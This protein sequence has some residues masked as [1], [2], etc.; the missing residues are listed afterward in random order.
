MTTTRNRLRVHV[1]ADSQVA[2]RHVDG[3]P[4]VLLIRSAGLDIEL[5]LPPD[6]RFGAVGPAVRLADRTAALLEYARA[7]GEQAVQ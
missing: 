4:L 1:D 5:I 7:R 2:V 3:Q 6:D